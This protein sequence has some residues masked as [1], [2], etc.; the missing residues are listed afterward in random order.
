MNKDNIDADG[1]RKNVGIIIC[2]SESQLL[3][4]GRI[5]NKGWQFPQGGVYQ[6]ETTDEA[7]YRELYE[8]VGLVK[9]NV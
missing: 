9:K 6:N 1:Y 8:E 2:N 4:A 5:A 7:M 3:L